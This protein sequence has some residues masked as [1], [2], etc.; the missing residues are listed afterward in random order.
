[1]ELLHLSLSSG[2]TIPSSQI[3]SLIKCAA[4][5]GVSSVLG[6]L[7]RTAAKDSEAFF[8]LCDAVLL[9][10]SSQTVSGLLGFLP[11]EWCED[12]AHSAADCTWPSVKQQL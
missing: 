1:M 9:H 12:V 7:Q 10:I 2:P 5:T 3:V 6:V 4:A 8:A 11:G